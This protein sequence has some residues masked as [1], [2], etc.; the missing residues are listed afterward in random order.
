MGVGLFALVFGIGALPIAFLYFAVETP[1]SLTERQVSG[2]AK[3]L[4]TKRKQIVAFLN[5]HVVDGSE[6]SWPGKPSS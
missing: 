1:N 3:Q 4:Q 5:V 6:R 2:E